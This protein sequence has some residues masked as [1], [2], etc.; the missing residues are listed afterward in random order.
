LP[1]GGVEEHPTH[2]HGVDADLQPDDYEEQ[3]E[4]AP[5]TGFEPREDEVASNDNEPATDDEAARNDENA[6]PGDV[7]VSRRGSPD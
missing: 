5:A 2:D 6:G 4:T 3:F 1:D 7:A